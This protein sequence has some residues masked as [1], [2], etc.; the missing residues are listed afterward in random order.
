MVV[1]PRHSLVWLD[2]EGWRAVLAQTPDQVCA[3]VIRWR[4][5]DWP[6]TVRRRDAD[7]ADDQLCLGIALPPMDGNKVRLPYRVKCSTIAQSQTALLLAEIVSALPLQWRDPALQLHM[8]AQ[9]A[10][11]SVQVYGSAA[12]QSITGLTYLQPSTMQHLDECIRL[13]QKFDQQL[14]LDGEIVFGTSAAVAAKEWCNTA[15]Q[16]GG[17][18]VL[19]KLAA[20]VALMRK[21][22]LISLLDQQPCLQT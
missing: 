19:A 20:G 7:C 5:A 6:L 8:A 4:D 21:D 9:M 13:F 12:L 22:A 14:P 17:F 18:R 11:V 10:G 16:D 3:Q 1:P 2:A 15:R